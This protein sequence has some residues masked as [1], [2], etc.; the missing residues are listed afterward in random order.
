MQSLLR[1]SS[2]NERELSQTTTSIRV[3]KIQ[4]SWYPPLKLSIL[5]QNSSSILLRS[6]WVAQYLLWPSHIHFTSQFSFT[7]QHFV[8]LRERPRIIIKEAIRRD[9]C[10]AALF[11]RRDVSSHDKVLTEICSLLGHFV[12]RYS[13]LCRLASPLRVIVDT[14]HLKTRTVDT[15]WHLYHWRRFRAVISA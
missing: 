3:L 6:Q 2:H 10:N 15:S 7:R 13:V 12:R 4:D 11:E 8:I 9:K 1:F 14:R 5:T